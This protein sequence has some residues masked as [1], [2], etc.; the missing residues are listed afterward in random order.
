MWGRIGLPGGSSDFSCIIRIEETQG[1]RDL[2]IIGESLHKDSYHA[3]VILNGNNQ[4][5]GQGELLMRTREPRFSESVGG[6]GIDMTEDD[7]RAKYG[8]PDTVQ[9]KTDDRG[10]VWKG[11]TTWSYKKLGR[12]PLGGRPGGPYV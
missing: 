10:R 5:E 8:N 6:I 3:H 11:N 9:P 4:D 2:P 7:V 12:G 1:Y